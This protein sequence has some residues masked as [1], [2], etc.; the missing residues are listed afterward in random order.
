MLWKCLQV[1]IYFHT[2]PIF[3]FHFKIAIF[4]TQH[5]FAKALFQYELCYVR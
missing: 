2:K 5:I 4:E 1:F 3:F